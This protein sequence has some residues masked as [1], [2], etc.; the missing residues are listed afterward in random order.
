MGMLAA[1]EAWVTR[2]HSQEWQTWLSWLDCIARRAA[3]IEGVSTRVDEPTGLSNH[4]PVLTISWDPAALHITGE[5]VAED[6]ARKK[7]R[8]AVGSRSE[9]GHTAIHITP[10]QMQPGNDEVVAERVYRILSEKRS[11]QSPWAVVDVNAMSKVSVRSAGETPPWSRLIPSTV[12]ESISMV[13]P[14]KV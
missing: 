12:S 1:V 6:F 2:D 9:N 7:P 14:K 11:P 4:A 8:I 13:A 10:N 5:E 3:E